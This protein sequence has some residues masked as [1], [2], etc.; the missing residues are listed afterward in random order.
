MRVLPV[1]LVVTLA[2]CTS[3]GPGEDLVTRPGDEYVF[4][5]ID[6]RDDMDPA[7]RAGRTWTVCSMTDQLSIDLDDHIIRYYASNTMAPL[8]G[9]DAIVAVTVD[10]DESSCNQGRLWPLHGDESLDLTLGQ[11]LP[12]RVALQDSGRF[13]ITVDWTDWVRWGDQHLFQ[14]NYV[15]KDSYGPH[16]RTVSVMVTHHGHWPT[17]KLVSA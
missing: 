15:G 1:L 4:V 9:A 14:W 6:G 12:V 17:D 16:N 11:G 8:E 5:W 13:D 10:V 7:D 2:G 3:C